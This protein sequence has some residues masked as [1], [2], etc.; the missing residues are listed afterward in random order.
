MIAR[1]ASERLR[2]TRP[3]SAEWYARAQRVVAGGVGHDLRW[4]TPAPTCIS[5]GQ[6]AYKWDVDG[7][8]YIDY[9]LGNAALLLG[10][11]HPAIVAAV[12]DAVGRGTHF[13][14]DHPA[15]IQWAEAVCRLV[16]CAERMRFVNSGSEANML[17][18]R[19]VRAFTGRGKLLRFDGH[20]HGWHDDLATGFAVP[21]DVPTTRGLAPGTP[22]GS[23][24]IPAND[25]PRLDAVLA[26]D[27]DIAA[28]ILEPSGASW[29][30][31]PLADGFLAGVRE[32]THRH[33]VLLIFDEVITG[34]RWAPGG[35]QERHGVVPDLSTHAKVIAGGMPGAAVCGRADVMDQM[36]IRGDARRDRYERV[37]HLG[38][39]NAN[40]VSA[41][42][43]LACLEI[44]ATGAPQR[45]ADAVAARLREGLDAV[46][47]KRG[48]AGYV[49]G[50]ASTFH[51]YL[52]AVPGSG[53]PRET[54]RTL[55]A[56]TLKSIPGAVVSAIQNG[57]RVRGVELMSYT[58][59]VTS[60][61]HSEADV[62][63]TVAAFDDLV[64]ALAG[65]VL[66]TL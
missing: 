32:V 53:R 51:I 20:F 16:P 27:R 10:H 63:E 54:L 4:A 44:V 58:G 29:G 23:L 55:D 60:A 13:G 61:A 31:V 35:A 12:R 41:A 1:D 65:P 15:Q 14:N 56:V 11:A 2:A 26:A 50:D 18:A 9:G 46:L 22:L 34:F 24:A 8:R 37:M 17:A 28:V 25:L 47:V 64:G 7:H 39:F 21:F 66:A 42:A 6:G 3:A 57:F 48:V 43:A 45:H 36:T 40:P 5:H 59:G 62:D 49:Y 33:G 52:E 38:T 30:T 19:L